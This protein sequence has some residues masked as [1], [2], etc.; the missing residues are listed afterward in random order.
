MFR[1]ETFGFCLYVRD[2][3]EDKMEGI[4][5]VMSDTSDCVYLFRSTSA[6]DLNTQYTLH[7]I[8]QSVDFTPM[9][10][11]NKV[12]SL[13]WDIKFY[14]IYIISLFSVYLDDL[15]IS[16]CTIIIIVFELV[17]LSLIHIML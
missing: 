10:H 14:Y 7:F 17:H 8:L 11:T 13:F 16:F 1:F 5:N 3:E 12:I 2:L 4:A 15:Q 6:A 9:C